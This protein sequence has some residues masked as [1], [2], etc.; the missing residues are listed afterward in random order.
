MTSRDKLL[1][2]PFISRVLKVFSLDLRSLAVFRLGMAAMIALDLVN[3]L[4]DL[5]AYYTDQGILP[6]DTLATIKDSWYWSINLISGEFWVQLLIFALALLIVLCLFLGYRTRLATIATWVMIVSIHHRNPLLLFAGD[7]VLRALL[8]WSMFLPLG[9]AYSLDSALNSASKPLPKAVVSGATVAFMVQL[10]FFYMWSV[11]YKHQSELWQ[12]GEAVYYS[13]NFEHYATHFGQLLLGLPEFVL[14]LF[15]WFTLWFELLG[16]LIIF[17]PLILPFVTVKWARYVAVILFCFLH[18]MFGLV[19]TLGIFPALSIFAWLAL[20]P[21]EFWQGWQERLQTPERIGLKINYDA[22]CGFCKKVVHLLRTFLILPG[23]PLLQAQDRPEIYADLQKYNSWVVEAAD[24]RRYYKWRGVIYVISLSPVFF[25]LAKILSWSPLLHLGTKFYEWIA[26]NRRFAGNFTKPLQYRPITVRPSLL[27]NV[28]T[29]LLLALASIWNWRRFTETLSWR[30]DLQS[31]WA[32]AQY[33]LLHRR[34]INQL[35]PLAKL[36]RLD[37]SWSI[38]A[39]NPPRDDGW[40]VIKAS[41]QDG[42]EV[43]L[44][45]PPHTPINWDKLTIGERQRLYK[46][47]QWRSFYIRLNR[48]VGDQVFSDYIAYLQNQWNSQHPPEQQIVSVEVYF[49]DETTVPPGQP[50]T[51]TR[52]KRQF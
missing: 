23:T 1:Q 39:P 33:K 35:E 52:V 6:R 12:N 24:G 14:K 32:E 37:Q 31:P 9:A 43:D 36:T 27:L 10:C 42:T 38:F 26:N 4:G 22:D 49:M 47:M 21:S 13:L 44:W 18:L 8:F 5:Q 40:Y 16:P 50:Q 7:D 2:H 11:A 41:L 19:F 45:R 48:A 28:A 29:L 51:V 30:Q 20:L 46:N 3:R 34:T 25:P 15:T 17:L